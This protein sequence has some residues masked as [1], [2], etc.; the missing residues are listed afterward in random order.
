LLL[1]FAWE[2]E[3]LVVDGVDGSARSLPVRVVGLALGAAQANRAREGLAVGGNRWV[4]DTE[5]DPQPS[6]RR[7]VQRFVFDIDG[8]V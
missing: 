8:G 3:V 7:L 1:E 2:L 5:V 4:D 6:G